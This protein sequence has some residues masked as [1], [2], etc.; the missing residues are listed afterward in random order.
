MSDRHL[1]FRSFVETQ[2]FTVPRQSGSPFR[3]LILEITMQV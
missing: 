3:K 1:T 2:S